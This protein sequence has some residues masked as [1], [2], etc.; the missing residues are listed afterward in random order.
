MPK[1]VVVIPNLNGGHALLKAVESLRRQ[2]I[3]A[4]IILVDNASADSSAQD[5]IAKYPD[6]EFVSNLRNEGYTGGVNPGFERAIAM[7]AQYVAPFN[8]D[9]VADP[10]WL[11]HLVKYLQTHPEVGAVAPK[12][13]NEDGSK[14]DST[15]DFYTFW[16]LP[17][18]RGRGSPK[19]DQYDDQRAVFAASGAASLYRVSALQQVGLLDQDFFA[20]YEDTDLSFRLQLA[21][22]KVA[23][24]PSSLVYHGIGMTS[25]RLK[26]FTTFQAMKNLQLLWFKN[27]PRKY[28]WRVGARLVLAQSFFFARAISRRQGGAALKG[29]ATGVYL[30]LKKRPERKSIQASR[31]AT[32]DYI[33]SILT[34]DLPANAHALRTLRQ[35]WW[36]LTF[37]KGEASEENSH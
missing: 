16:G 15:G 9:A 4:H 33:W 14:L 3:E 17:Y 22:W 37:R 29:T 18:P 8:N 12:V 32:D 34:H 25:S 20:Y 28:L 23:Y 19:T 10:Q 1:P 21:G 31:T 36:R 5:V 35:L 6:V 30:L 7:K 2:T 26:G 24:E 13:V 11:E 27:V